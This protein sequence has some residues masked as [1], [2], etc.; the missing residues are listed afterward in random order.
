MSIEN[1]KQ[2]Q[3][4]DMSRS[5]FLSWHINHP[6][7][8]LEVDETRIEYPAGEKYVLIDCT[9]GTFYTDKS[10]KV[11]EEKLKMPV[12]RVTPEPGG[13]FGND[14]TGTVFLNDLLAETIV[15]QK[16]YSNAK[17]P[18]GLATILARRNT[19]YS[20]VNR[21]MLGKKF[22]VFKTLDKETGKYEI[23]EATTA[24]Y[25][26]RCELHTSD[27][28]LRV[29]AARS[30]LTPEDMESLVRQ[31]SRRS[32]IEGGFGIPGARDKAKLEQQEPIKIIMPNTAVY[33]GAK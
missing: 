10:L 1:F 12:I 24:Q 31:D 27:S 21:T 33:V 2:D 20:G 16:L 13:G 22:Q 19:R 25:L 14:P 18:W 9:D 8:L 15:S 32:I 26:A 11:L 6:S 4:A 3:N 28:M 29:V 23:V 30:Y 7:E 17:D 5:E